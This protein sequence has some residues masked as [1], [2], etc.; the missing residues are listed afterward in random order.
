[1]IYNIIDRRKRELRWRYV[2]AV[3]QPT[4]HDNGPY[5]DTDNI[6][7]LTFAASEIDYD[8]LVHVS[9]H[10]AIIW[11]ERLPFAV[12]L[13]L[14]DDGTENITH[15]GDEVDRI[16]GVREVAPPMAARKN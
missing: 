1:M 2:Y 5:H 13:H 16:L 3:V 4:H 10:D 11:A 15:T 7:P 6:D 12:T 9:V 8:E 14:Y